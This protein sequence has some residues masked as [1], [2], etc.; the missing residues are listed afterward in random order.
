M[1]GKIFRFRLSLSWHNIIDFRR[2]VKAL[3]SAQRRENHFFFSPFISTHVK[4][5][6]NMH[7]RKG[8]EES[9][10]SWCPYSCKISMSSILQKLLNGFLLFFSSFTK[11]NF[12][13]IDFPL[14]F[15]LL[16][17]ISPPGFVF[18]YSNQYENELIWDEG[19]LFI[20]RILKKLYK[21]VVI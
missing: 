21:S 11:K 13:L 16:T 1:R 6:S 9:K 19:K 5:W 3:F 2:L 10:V 20:I 12:R 15:V 7:R 4:L 18:M 8:W 17:R 14:D